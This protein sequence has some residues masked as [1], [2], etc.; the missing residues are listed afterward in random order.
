M[1]PFFRSATG[2]ETDLAWSRL[3]PEAEVSRLAPVSLRPASE[4]F[5]DIDLATVEIAVVGHGFDQKRMVRPSKGS[6]GARQPY[7]IDRKWRPGQGLEARGEAE[8]ILAAH[9][10]PIG[11]M[12]TPF[13]WSWTSDGLFWAE[14]PEKGGFIVGLDQ[15]GGIVGLDRRGD[16]RV[17][18]FKSGEPVPVVV[19]LGRARRDPRYTAAWPDFGAVAWA[20]RVYEATE[21]MSAVEAEL[22]SPEA[23]REQLVAALWHEAFR[24]GAHLT[25]HRLRALHDPLL[26]KGQKSR[27]STG[28]GGRKT[29]QLLQS[30]RAKNKDEALRLAQVRLATGPRDDGKPWTAPALAVE[31][32]FAWTNG[33]Q[34]S[35]STLT[36]FVR[37]ARASGDSRL[38][39]FTSP[40]SR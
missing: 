4:P 17:W 27:Q 30:R 25:E 3:L 14:V 16:Q 7:E 12:R 29:T 6:L 2:D 38:A 26:V 20:R 31:I 9:N 8:E 39:A 22:A 23:D 32:L 40:P 19:T 11:Y 34:P 10:H 28:G 33:P 35:V 13:A 1:T 18:K 37:E 15:D 24:L 5:G 36:A 21:T